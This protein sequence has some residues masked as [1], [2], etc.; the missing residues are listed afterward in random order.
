VQQRTPAAPGA[1][2]ERALRSHADLRFKGVSVGPLPHP[3]TEGG[4]P[5]GEDPALLDESP[6]RLTDV[7]ERRRNGAGQSLSK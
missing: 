3:G 4:P 1:R 5:A 7:E 6:R 2:F